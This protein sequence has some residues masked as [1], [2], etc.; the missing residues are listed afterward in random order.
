V[1]SREEI[2]TSVGSPDAAE[3]LLSALGMRQWFRAEK[4]RE[5]YQIDDATV[6]VDDTPI[7]VYVEIESDP[8]RIAR[9][10]LLLGRAPDDYRLDS[11]PQLYR[12]WCGARGVAPG[13]MVFG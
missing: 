12:Q 9:V 3:A 6:A 13:N 1:K 11:Y 10:A 7:G 5:E 2:E 4:Y 8:A